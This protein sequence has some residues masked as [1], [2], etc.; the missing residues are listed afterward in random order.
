MLRATLVAWATVGTVLLGLSFGVRAEVG[1]PTSPALSGKVTS[2]SEGAMEGVIIGAKKA[3]STITT[4]VVSNAEG[5]YAFPRERL[6]PGKYAI[7]IRAVGY[8][9]PETSVEVKTYPVTHDLQLDKV[10]DNMELAAQLSNTEWFMSMPGTH[11]QKALLGGCT[12]CHTLQRILFSRH[13]ESEMVDVVRRMHTHTNNSSSEH[14]WTIPPATLPP[15]TK[16]DIAIAKYV[17]S[18]NLSSTGKFKFPLKTLPRPTGKATR[19]IY[20]TYDLPRPDNAPH[21]VE[22]DAY[23][24]AWYADFTSQFIGKLDIT[25]GKAVEYAVPLGRKGPNAHGG[26]QI[27]LDKQG[28]VYYGNMFQ[29]QFVRFDPDTG[30]MQQF[31]PPIP[32]SQYGHGHIT[33]IDPWFKDVDGW[34]WLNVAR[35]TDESG[36]TWHVNPSTNT[37]QQVSYPEGSPSA[38]AYDVVANSDNDMYG[39]HMR[40][41]RIWM[42]SGKTLKTVW[43]HF[44]PGGEGCR[45]GHIDNRD[46]VW[47]ADFNGNR[48]AMFDPETKKVTEWNVPTP[49]VRPYDAEF[50]DRTYDWGAGMDSDLAVRMNTKTGE[51]T[52][53]LLPHETNVRHV[54]V[55]KSAGLSSFWLGDQHGSGVI[56]VEPLAP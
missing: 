23:G 8:K 35:G 44:P 4:W 40:N 1:T 48:L 45:R 26:L 34:I 16:N 50:D 31:K 17:S 3:D 6:A 27:A 25:T 5:R 15:T 37:W 9:L 11:E 51:F 52:E 29:M 10:T 55:Q 53:Y 14:P 21:D 20:T 36:G 18:I 47:C 41:P 12:T 19:V 46:R 22:L 42:T 49:W 28:L 13:D 24:N 30:K 43:Y 56:H 32:E 2:Q 7:S 54:E 33:M 38:R 39:M